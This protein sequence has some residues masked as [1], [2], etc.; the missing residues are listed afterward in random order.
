MSYPYKYLCLFFLYSLSSLF[1]EQQSLFGFCSLRITSSCPVNFSYKGYEPNSLM[2]T[3]MIIVV[4]EPGDFI[5][6][7]IMILIFLVIDLSLLKGSEEPFQNC[8][9][10]RNVRPGV[11][12]QDPLVLQERLEALCPH[13]KS[14]CQSGY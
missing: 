3:P 2:R 10:F 4:N 12:I 13:L 1:L 6:S 11:F 8:L 9:I 7:L 5:F 14:Y